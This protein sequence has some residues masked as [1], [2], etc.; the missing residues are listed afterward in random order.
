GVASGAGSRIASSLGW[1]A[2]AAASMPTFARW[3]QN[4]G[5][6]ARGAGRF[7][8]RMLINPV[9]GAVASGAILGEGISSGFSADGKGTIRT[10]IEAWRTRSRNR[11]M[12][13]A[14][15]EGE[16]RRAERLERARERDAEIR[17]A[18]SIRAA[19]RSYAE[20]DFL[21]SQY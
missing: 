12:E 20:Q 11:Y 21:E 19:S 7:A 17:R 9:T 18:A 15:S 6:L 16:M 5:S 14:L 13:Q 4:A 8:G 2:A 3:A 10:G 1:G